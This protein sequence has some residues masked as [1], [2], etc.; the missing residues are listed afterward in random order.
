MTGDANQ[1]TLRLGR[2]TPGFLIVGLTLFHAINNWIWLD[3]NVMTRGWDRIGSLVNSLFY[4]DTLSAFSLQALFKATIQDAYR[5]P[6]F[7]LSMA[8]MY[9]LFGVSADVAV[10]VNVVFLFILFAASYGIGARLGGRRLGMLGAVLVALIPLVYAMSRYSYFEFSLT[11]LTALSIYFL[12]ACER[13]ERKGASLLLGVSL[14]LGALVKRTFPVFI[15]GAAVIVFFQAGLPRQIWTWLRAGLG[16]RAWSR[17]RWRDLVVALGGGLLLSALW[18]FPNRQAAQAL[19]AGSWF[20][21]LWWLL[22]SVAIFAV[23]QRSSPVTNFVTSIA[24]ALTIASVW[25]LPHGFEFVKQILW[26]AWGIEDPRGRTVDLTSLT[27]YT[28]YLQSIFYGFSP[29]YAL[30]LVVTVGLLLAY[31]IRHRQRLLPVPWWS[32]KWWPILATLFVSYA[33]LSTSIYKE[34]RAITPIL[35]LLGVIL[36][37]ALLKLP[38]RRL[39]A[40]LIVLAIG[41]GLVQFFAISYTGPHQLVERTYFKKPVLGQWSVFAQGLYLETPDSGLNDPDFWIAEDVLQQVDATRRR[42]GWDTISL[43]IIAYSSHV[44]V[45]MFA[46][47]QIRLYPEIQLEDPTESYPQES[48]YST[49]FR[50]DYVLVLK[51]KNRRPAVRDAENLILEERRFLFDRAFEEEAHYTLPDG[52]EAYLFRRRLR[53]EITYDASSLYQSVEYLQQTATDQDLVVVHPP[54]LS[55]GF[56]EHYTGPAPVSSLD[57]VE[58]LERRPRIF[59]LVD[60]NASPGVMTKLSELGL[61]TAERQFGELQMLVFELPNP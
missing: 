1:G 27:T 14:G 7:G 17:S 49:A 42:E 20:F 26:L 29:V 61:P 22:I 8:T 43:G 40:A 35:P 39:R 33:I 21:P 55:I 57:E 24:V 50:Y 45:G 60:Q 51:N 25:Y 28:D 23:L 16:L 2:W 30:L 38:W 12:L 9:K 54:D 37:A 3:K 5:P 10:M 18:Y 58:V 59:V 47:D 53:P 52:S 11:A 32:W 6:L 56:L 19:S 31:A 36:A 4:Y 15:M 44:H 48:A 46:Y 41:F 34:D 13:F